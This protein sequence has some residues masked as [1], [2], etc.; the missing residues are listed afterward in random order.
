MKKQTY[1][2]SLILFCFLCCFVA[3][4][5]KQETI[6]EKS[7]DSKNYQVKYYDI[8][9]NFREIWHMHYFF[10]NLYIAAKK[11]SGDS[12]ICKYNKQG[13]F[14]EEITLKLKE[15]ISI[16]DFYL[17]EDSDI[18][19]LVTDNP[20]KNSESSTNQTSFIK[21]IHFNKKGEKLSST[22]LK[23]PYERNSKFEDCGL[24]MKD[25]C[26]AILADQKIFLFDK[27]GNL[28]NQDKIHGISPCICLD[29]HKNLSI[30]SQISSDYIV[31]QLS[32]SSEKISKEYKT[33]LP[34]S[35]KYW[36]KTADKDSN[37]DFITANTEG[38]YGYSYKTK[39]TTSL[40]QWIKLNIVIKDGSFLDFSCL[41][42]DSFA[43]LTYYPKGTGL[44]LLMVEPQEN[45]RKQ[46][47][48]KELI[49]YNYEVNNNNLDY[50]VIAWNQQKK[51]Y[52]ISMKKGVSFTQL[53]LD[54]VAGNGP[55]ILYLPNGM[56]TFWN[57]YIKKGYFADYDT[58]MKQKPEGLQ[59]K[60][61]LENLKTIYEETYGSLY[62]LPVS[63][64]VKVL[65][66]KKQDF[67][68]KKQGT[69][70]EFNT[71]MKKYTPIKFMDDQRGGF[72]TEKQPL[73]YELFFHSLSDFYD[74]TSG[75][76]VEK[77]KE[78]LNFVM[79][80]TSEENK[81]ADR[82]LLYS[83]VI[84][85]MSGWHP[86]LK[87]IE[88]IYGKNNFQLLGYPCETGTGISII[89][90]GVF[91]IVAN[92]NSSTAWDFVQS[93][94]SYEAQNRE[95]VLDEEH[96]YSICF[97]FPIRK[98]AFEER[99]QELKS[100][101][102]YE[103]LSKKYS[104]TKKELDMLKSYIECADRIYTNDYNLSNIL[105]DELN[106]YFDGEKDQE[107]ILYIIENRMNL[108]SKEQKE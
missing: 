102:H 14:L 37:Y 53:S 85:G 20:W 15:D 19:C 61:L 12:V 66:G 63:F 28:S 6:L 36:T 21:S 68:E 56:D 105:T 32:V 77:F 87:N 83:E 50:G 80:W 64:T 39:K 86:T 65:A 4:Q 59:K 88:A 108:Y 48:K 74:T 79:Q 2:F 54:I 29:S 3:C 81:T 47:E 91:A 82:S 13:T 95:L 22:K 18:F 76:N 17:S 33:S 43:V 75:L 67:P 31:Q 100:P 16:L 52:E 34:S 93:F 35:G 97:D 8:D 70:N 78:L 98:D 44:R 73:F 94:Y 107:D 72:L 46:Q 104:A 10:D 96:P 42:K 38:I 11:T 90:K 84:S 23:F 60:D 24:F 101:N 45:N 27:D 1:F 71:L 5:N 55:D 40:F 30:L 51:D 69:L 58:L 92:E 41:E 25:S 99:F 106:A 7:D 103:G 89:E 26:I 49:L 57:S 62:F 9:N